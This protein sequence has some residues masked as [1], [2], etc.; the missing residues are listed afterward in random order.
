MSDTQ[1]G[2]LMFE[3]CGFSSQREYVAA[4]VLLQYG[5]DGYLEK[6]DISICVAERNAKSHGW[7]TFSDFLENSRWR[8]RLHIASENKSL[9]ASD[10]WKKNNT[11]YDGTH[12][13]HARARKVLHGLI[14]TY[15][16]GR[17]SR[18]SFRYKDWADELGISK[19]R[20]SQY[21]LGQCLPD[22]EL[23]AKMLQ[24][25][26]LR[27]TTLDDFLRQHEPRQDVRGKTC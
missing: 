13:K 16:E 11:A 27:C 3:K 8:L 15:V 10:L 24:A 1:T 22:S 17:K 23:L 18:E 14:R 7:D 26:N 6:P 9:N 21:A 5:K 12:A 4:R 25:M 19:A 20:M 2:R